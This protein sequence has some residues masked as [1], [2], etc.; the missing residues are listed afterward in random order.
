MTLS[1]TL[2]VRPL[3]W[4]AVIVGVPAAIPVTRPDGVIVAR[5][6]SLLVQETAT[7]RSCVVVSVRVPVAVSW[8]V[9]PTTTVG[10]AGPIARL[11]RTGAVTVRLAEAETVPAAAVIVIVPSVR[12]VAR[13]P[14]PIAATPGSLLVQRTL[15]VR[16]RRLP[17]E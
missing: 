14:T 11:A 4:V 3:A 12:P 6:A 16:S 5:V 13:P 7:V 17:S 1:G 9:W 15:P 2:A 10:V 8:S